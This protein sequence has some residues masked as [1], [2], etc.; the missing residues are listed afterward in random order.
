MAEKTCA[1]CTSVFQGVGNEKCCSAECRTQWQRAKKRLEKAR[2][3]ARYPEKKKQ[4]RQRYYGKHEKRL[5][6]RSADTNRRTQKRVERLAAHPEIAAE[7]DRR[8]AAIAAELSRTHTI[9][10]CAECG[11]PFVARNNVK[12]CSDECW[13]TRHRR[14]KRRPMETAVPDELLAK[15]RANQNSLNI[16]RKAALELVHEIETKGLGALL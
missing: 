16:R 12:T 14:L 2:Y 6:K 7:V 11:S 10:E 5:A 15:K 8:G 3:Y 4:E 9:K 1:V 13:L